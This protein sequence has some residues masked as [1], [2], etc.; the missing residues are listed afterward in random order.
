[1]K[2][3]NYNIRTET[4]QKFCVSTV[5]AHIMSAGQ[6]GKIK[7]VIYKHLYLAL[8]C[9]IPDEDFAFMPG[10]DTTPQLL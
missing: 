4:S 2:G 6:D 5:Q 7:K 9:H 1:M 8:C 3:S 10:Q